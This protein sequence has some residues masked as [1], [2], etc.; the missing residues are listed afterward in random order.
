MMELVNE[1]FT[2]EEKKMLLELICNEQIHMIIKDHEKYG[3]DKYKKLEEL[4][5]KIKDL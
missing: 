3:T 5:L 1:I 2:K 4:K